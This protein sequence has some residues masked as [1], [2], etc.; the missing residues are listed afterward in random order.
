[1]Q[2][3]DIL[4]LAGLR[5]DGR[6]PDEMRSIRLRLGVTPMADGSV[7]YEQGLNKILVNAHGP[8]EP[9][10]RADDQERGAINVQI[11]NASFSGTD[12]KKRRA[13][14]DKRSAEMETSI[15]HTFEG[16]V[17]LELY[18]RSEIVLVVHVLES[19][20]SAL[21]AIINAVSMA[22]MHAGIAMKDMVVA[23]SVGLVH[24]QMC[25]DCTHME[26]GSGGAYMPIAIK[27][28]SEEVLLISLDARLSVANLEAAMQQAIH[29]CRK[30]RVQFEADMK[31]YMAAM[32]QEVA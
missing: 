20:G 6:R 5:I 8:Q 1:M 25:Q 10:R 11:V 16:V 22:L 30:L 4:A 15:Q 19:D 27:A 24:E 13:G 29:G 21:C 7:Y 31:E 23:C 18:P 12:W 9:V 17:M 2:H 32:L 26:Q 3:A 14:G 28:R